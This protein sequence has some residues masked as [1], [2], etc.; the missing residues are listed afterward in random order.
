MNFTRNRLLEQNFGMCISPQD[1]I[2]PCYASIGPNYHRPWKWCIDSEVKDFGSTIDDQKDKF[3]ITL[4][5][6][7]F[8][9]NEISVKVIG[10]EIIVEGKHEDRQDNHG[11]VSRQFKR[12]YVLPNECLSEQVSSTLSS[13]GLLSVIARKKTTNMHDKEITVPIEMCGPSLKKEAEMKTESNFRQL[14]DNRNNDVEVKNLVNFRPKE[15]LC[16]LETNKSNNVLMCADKMQMEARKETDKLRMTSDI[17]QMDACTSQMKSENIVEQSKASMEELIEKVSETNVTNTTETSKFK[18]MKECL[19][20]EE[21][22]SYKSSITSRM[23][24]S[25]EQISEFVSEAISAELKEAAE[26]I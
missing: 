5:V 12:R 8:L 1:L 2:V 21:I 26:N 17:V 4:D 7:H 24:M 15:D 19:A 10:K 14:E 6:Q 13:D 23:K 3:Q 18:S 11:V 9:P 16:F 20:S 25:G 22:S